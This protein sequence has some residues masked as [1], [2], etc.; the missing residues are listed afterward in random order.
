MDS[1]H[2]PEGQMISEPE[3]WM[4]NLSRTFSSLASIELH[5]REWTIA[6]TP[7]SASIKLSID[8]LFMHRINFELWYTFW[9]YKKYIGRGITLHRAR[10][11]TLIRNAIFGTEFG[12]VAPQDL[13][14][15]SATQ[16]FLPLEIF[17]EK[18]K[19]GK[20]NLAVNRG[21]LNEETYLFSNT[22]RRR[23]SSRRCKGRITVAQICNGIEPFV[24]FL[25][26]SAYGPKM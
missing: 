5:S 16:L 8:P 11:H 20:L 22:R 24:L 17:L 18:L 6:P 2:Q 13:R 15:G 1:L 21:F 12:Q 3:K 23:R 10:I 19:P 26:E 14:A 25:F 4:P 7:L 9:Q